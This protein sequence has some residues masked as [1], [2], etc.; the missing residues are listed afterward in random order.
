GELGG[1]RGGRPPL[2][3]PEQA[4]RP[5]RGVDDALPFVDPAVG[6][7]GLDLVAPV[8]G[9]ERRARPVVARERRRRGDVA[10]LVDRG[11]GGGGRRPGR[12]AGAAGD[13]RGRGG[14]A[15][16]GA[17]TRRAARRGRREEQPGQ[18]D[19][20]QPVALPVE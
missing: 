15:V 4:G 8:G 18:G 11:G 19:G 20:R 16:G 6:V 13:R 10:L 1:A 3:L 14:R 9:G 5:L 2:G 7:A 12:G 17:V